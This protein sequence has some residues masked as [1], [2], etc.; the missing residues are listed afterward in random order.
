ML[1]VVTNEES[2]ILSRSF[3]KTDWTKRKFDDCK[4]Y[5]DE[6]NTL[7]RDKKTDL[8]K[9]N[10]VQLDKPKKMSRKKRKIYKKRQETKRYAQR[11][12]NLIE[13][14]ANTYKC[15]TPVVKQKYLNESPINLN[16]EKMLSPSTAGAGYAV[17]KSYYS[18]LYAQYASKIDQIVVYPNLKN[19]VKKK[20]I[21]TDTTLR[22]RNMLRTMQKSVNSR[23]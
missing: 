10:Y 22:L 8:I 21:P 15:D 9:Y 7:W 5:T 13:S 2:P 11:L 12:I 19:V 23:Y 17:N 16:L 20:D 1:F 18:D 3:Y 4:P 14:H 6:T